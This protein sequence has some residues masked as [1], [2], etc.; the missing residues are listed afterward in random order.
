MIFA[1]GNSLRIAMSAS[2]AV[3]FRH[4]QVHQ[5]DVRTMRPELLDR[6]PAVG[7][8]AHQVISGWM[9]DETGDA[10]ADDGMVIDRENSNVQVLALMTR[11]LDHAFTL[12]GKLSDNQ[13]AAPD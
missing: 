6:L 1:S 12:S 3:H 11:L 7:R 2:S 8:F 13:E 4:L 10:L 5:R 9:L